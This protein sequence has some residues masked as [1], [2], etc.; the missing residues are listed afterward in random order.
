MLPSAAGDSSEREELER[1]KVVGESETRQIKNLSAPDESGTVTSWDVP[2]GDALADPEATSVRFLRLH[3]HQRGSTPAHGTV[4]LLHGGYWKN[5]FGLDDA[6]GN[7][8]IITLAPFFSSKGYLPIEVEFRRRDHAG[9]GWPGTNHDILDAL[10]CL[11]NLKRSGGVLPGRM[12]TGQPQTQREK[13]VWA[14]TC[15]A[16]DLERLIVVGHSAGGQLALW[17][18]HQLVTQAGWLLPKSCICVAVSPCADL[19]EGHAMRV[20]EDGDA[21]ER[22]MKGS[23]EDLPSEY[24]LACPSRHL[25]VTYP[26]LIAYGDADD[27]VP[28][29]LMEA[30]AAKAIASN[31][32]LVSAVVVAGADHFAVTNAASSAWRDQVVPGLAE[33]VGRHFGEEARRALLA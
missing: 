32:D 28:P 4:A 25:P 8:G 30:Y 22:Y 3:A 26:L 14:D 1:L 19:H 16:L 21:V 17:T 7:A 9:G 10:V 2:Y 20:S 13:D 33:V 23:P 29:V 15:N 12:R 5:M 24:A 27:D 11:G 31:S 6:Y 18:A